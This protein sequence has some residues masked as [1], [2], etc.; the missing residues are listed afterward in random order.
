M[1]SRQLGSSKEIRVLR[2]KERSLYELCVAGTVLPIVN[3]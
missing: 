3:I 1:R 2:K